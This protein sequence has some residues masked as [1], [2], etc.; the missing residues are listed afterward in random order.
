MFKGLF[1]PK[2]QEPAPIPDTSESEYYYTEDEIQSPADQEPASNEEEPQPAQQEPQAQP[3]IINPVTAK[4]AKK[5]R[6]PTK[7]HAHERHEIRR[8]YH[9]V[10]DLYSH[11]SHMILR[12][13]DDSLAL[14]QRFYALRRK[15][16]KL[17]KLLNLK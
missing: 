17:E 4:V 8:C 6:K 1:S 2:E 16:F 15:L 7:S 11:C 12:S 5:F 3:P 9:R 14:E 13:T 10:L